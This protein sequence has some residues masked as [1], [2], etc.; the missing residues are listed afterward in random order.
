MQRLRQENAAITAHLIATKQV[1]AGLLKDIESL[2]Q[3]KHAVLQRKVGRLL[4]VVGA[5]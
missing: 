4:S 5:L 3:E 2:K 1:Q